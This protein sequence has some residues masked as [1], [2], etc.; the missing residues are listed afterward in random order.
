MAFPVTRHTLIQRLAQGGGGD[1]WLDFH[2]DY[3]GVVCR[4]AKS[5]GQLSFEDSE[6]VASE[7]FETI[8]RAKLFQRWSESR[9]A[10]LRTLI[11]SVVRNVLSNRSRVAQGRARVVRD[12]LG[13]LDRY[14]P[15][16]PSEPEDPSPEQIDAFAAAWAESLVQTAIDDLFTEYNTAKKAD[17]FRVLYGRLCEDLSMAEIAM[18]LHIPV[19]SAD[20]FF[21][22]ARGR[23]TE[24]LEELVRSHV[25]RYCPPEEVTEEFS[26]EWN[27]LKESLQ[28]HGGLESAIRVMYSSDQPTFRHQ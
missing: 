28:R 13:Q 26:L 9:T 24:R 16:S 8:L 10:K 11:C 5:A 2:R 14:Q 15:H 19:T 1:D 18:S 17:Y 6:D 22:H 23:L 27:R 4:F 21:R 12:H 3:W 25:R 7:V 20:N